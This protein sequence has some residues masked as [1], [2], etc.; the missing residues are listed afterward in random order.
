MVFLIFMQ[1]QTPR[2]TSTQAQWSSQSSTLL[3][4]TTQLSDSPS[5]NTLT[6][7]YTRRRTYYIYCYIYKYCSVTY[8]YTHTTKPFNLQPQKMSQTSPLT[9]LLST[10][11]PCLRGLKKLLSRAPAL[12]LSLPLL[13]GSLCCSLFV[14]HQH[15]NTSRPKGPVCVSVCVC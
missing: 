4:N 15:D 12:F 7:S 1:T 10:Y 6:V 5:L 14:G 8:F 9:L 13:N 3:C 2:H 11:T